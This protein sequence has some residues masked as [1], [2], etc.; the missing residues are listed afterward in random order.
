MFRNTA[1][2][3]E[4]GVD[5]RYLL[6]DIIWH[7]NHINCLQ[8]FGT[9]TK[10][11]LFRHLTKLKKSLKTAAESEG[12]SKQ[13][14]NHLPTCS[15]TKILPLHSRTSEE[16]PCSESC[17]PGHSHQL[18]SRTQSIN[19]RRKC[20]VSNLLHCEYKCGIQFHS[21]KINKYSNISFFFLDR[22]IRSQQWLD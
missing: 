5:Q 7:R 2:T 15:L 1:F 17:L 10:P 11:D 20:V 16:W 18:H 6:T 3:N 4:R 12:L 14:S 13:Q 8:I 19:P 22:S 21:N 9:R